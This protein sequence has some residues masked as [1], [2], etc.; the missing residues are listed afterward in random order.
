MD[1]GN[2]EQWPCIASGKRAGGVWLGS[3]PAASASA[4]ALAACKAVPPD[5]RGEE[6]KVMAARTECR[7][8][9]GLSNMDCPPHKWP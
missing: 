5:P 3:P 2:S 8:G 6:A 7:R 9:P 4:A 1:S